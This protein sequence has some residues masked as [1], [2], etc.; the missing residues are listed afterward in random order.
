[1]ASDHWRVICGGVRACCKL[2]KGS[3]GIRI[4]PPVWWIIYELQV[5]GGTKR[6]FSST[7]FPF[8]LVTK[9]D[10]QSKRGFRTPLSC[11]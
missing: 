1:M 11:S 9:K 7:A 5:A 6:L 3:L 10:V 2:A 8:N 4:R